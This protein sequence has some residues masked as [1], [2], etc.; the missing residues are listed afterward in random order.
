MRPLVASAARR[1]RTAATASAASKS[2]GEKWD[3][4]SAVIVERPA[5]LTKDLGGIERTVCE[6]MREIEDER[7]LK[8]DFELRRERDLE[9]AARKKKGL[10]PLTAAGADSEMRMADDLLEEWKKD[11]KQFEPAP[12]RTKADEENDL[13]STQRELSRPLRLVVETKWPTGGGDSEGVWDL[14]TTKWREG[15]TM[16][17]TAERALRETCGDGLGAQVLGN[18]PFA[19]Y[20][21]GHGVKAREITNSKGGKVIN[22]VVSSA[23]STAYP[24]LNSILQVFVYKAFYESG[25]ASEVEDYSRDFKWLT[26]EPFAEALPDH[27]SKCVEQTVCDET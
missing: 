14:P 23:P 18:A 3:L 15:E 5:S 17:E 10:E 25:N 13:R 7:S 2:E 22:Q 12:T 20:K 4:W 6:T 11:A 16:R 21:F 9:N 24:I 1:T 8:S 26:W 19:M 27:V